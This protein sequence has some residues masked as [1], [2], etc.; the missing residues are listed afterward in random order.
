MHIALVTDTWSPQVNGVVR[1]L[2]AI[3]TELTAAGHAVSPL[4]AQFRQRAKSQA[5]NS[6]SRLSNEK[7]RPRQADARCYAM[8]DVWSQVPLVI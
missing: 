8:S 5:S 4:T 3:V 2:S 1:T 6:Q 7:G